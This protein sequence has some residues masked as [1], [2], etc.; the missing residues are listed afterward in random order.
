MTVAGLNPALAMRQ[1]FSAFTGFIPRGHG[2]GTRVQ[3][4]ALPSLAN[5][6]QEGPLLWV[7]WGLWA[8]SHSCPYPPNPALPEAPALLGNAAQSPQEP[9]LVSS[10]LIG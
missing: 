10:R 4:P 1:I 7:C 8:R 9:D 5:G 2:W 6:R 3:N